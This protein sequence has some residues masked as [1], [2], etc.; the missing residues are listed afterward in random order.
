MA[1]EGA[2]LQG[3][4]LQAAELPAATQLLKR[5]HEQLPCAA[6]SRPDRQG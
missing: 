2:L 6:D 4:V 5:W 1:I 3:E